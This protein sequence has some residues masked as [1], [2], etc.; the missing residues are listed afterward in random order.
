MLSCAAA[1]L[2]CWLVETWADTHPKEM[3]Q[4]R[5]YAGGAVAKPSRKPPPTPTSVPSPVQPAEET[6]RS[7][8]SVARGC[9][10]LLSQ[11]SLSYRVAHSVEWH[12]FWRSTHHSCVVDPA[13]LL[14]VRDYPFVSL[15]VLCHSPLFDPLTLASMQ[16]SMGA[17]DPAFQ[18]F[19]LCGITRLG[20]DGPVDTGAIDL[21]HRLLSVSPDSP[22]WLSLFRQLRLDV[23]P[24]KLTPLLTDQELAAMEKHV[25][26]MVLPY[27]ATQHLLEDALATLTGQLNHHRPD[28]AVNHT[29]H[30]VQPVLLETEHALERMLTASGTY[31]RCCMWQR[32]RVDMM[33]LSQRA[34]GQLQPS[35]SSSDTIATRL[36]L[37]LHPTTLAVQASAPA[38]GIGGAISVT[39]PLLHDDQACVDALSLLVSQLEGCTLDMPTLSPL[40]YLTS[41]RE[42]LWHTLLVLTSLYVAIVHPLSSALLIRPARKH[43]HGLFDDFHEQCLLCL[44]QRLAGRGLQLPT[45]WMT[46]AWKEA[47]QVAGVSVL[48]FRVFEEI[49]QLAMYT[50]PH[51]LGS[52]ANALPIP[53]ATKQSDSSA[54]GARG[55][56]SHPDTPVNGV[57]AAETC[58]D[59]RASRPTP[60]A[61]QDTS[62]TAAVLPLTPSLAP[63]AVC[64]SA[65]ADA[66]LLPCQHASCCQQC[67]GKLK[68]QYKSC[69]RPGCTSGIQWIIAIE[70]KH[71]TQ[72]VCYHVPPATA[73][74]PPPGKLSAPLAVVESTLSKPPPQ[75]GSVSQQSSS[76]PPQSMTTA[77]TQ[78]PAVH[79][80]ASTTAPPPALANEV[81]VA[82]VGSAATLSVV[83][84]SSVPV[85]P[86]G[87]A[88]VFDQPIDPLLN[89][90]LV[91]SD[92]KIDPLLASP[93]VPIP[94]ASIGTATIVVPPVDSIALVTPA[95]QAQSLPPALQIPHL[96]RRRVQTGV[97]RFTCSACNRM[98]EGN[99]SNAHLHMTTHHNVRNVSVVYEDGQIKQRKTRANQRVMLTG[100]M[101]PVEPMEP[102]TGSE[103]E[104]AESDKPKA[105]EESR[106]ARSTAMP[107]D[108]LVADSTLA[109]VRPIGPKSGDFIEQRMVVQPALPI[110]TISS[111][112]VSSTTVKA[113]KPFD[114]TAPSKPP[115][116]L[117]QS[118]TDEV[119]RV[120]HQVSRAKREA[121]VADNER[122]SKWQ[123]VDTA[124]ESHHAALHS[125]GHNDI[126]VNG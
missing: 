17:A 104:A 86:L 92:S 82:V 94:A 56:D 24:M 90:A 40:F 47:A 50:D 23:L 74:E 79:F 58:S 14:R 48:V 55:I 110:T 8:R 12:H 118:Y 70:R 15:A 124:A 5:V 32:C 30:S 63:C 20:W 122:Q 38:D 6:L 88:V 76:Q 87:A 115:P 41:A 84:H 89:L 28:T 9:V 116:S 111:A 114:F 64:N 96:R 91:A 21:M 16:W 77:A 106:P 107:S 126:A 125:N 83:P 2:Y 102:S 73:S 105:A 119:A 34:V 101:E 68:E 43:E 103:H 95:L 62:T 46:A 117:P 93:E 33:W 4:L 65:E 112:L 35:Q 18:L 31:L 51:S 80:L 99:S 22:G 54:N 42:R 67:A 57:K 108:V 71:R 25:S 13:T 69:P 19:S 66:L 3:A 26:L 72:E 52:Q 45:T 37:F 11:L 121:E 120:Q 81:K 39:W 27:E 78:S 109:A 44:E 123:R 85:T 61:P 1:P 36:R 113:A 100:P 60:A 49:N 53:L 75:T 29:A 59:I 10:T 7:F 97:V 98:F